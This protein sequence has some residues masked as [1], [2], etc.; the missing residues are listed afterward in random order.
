MIF[1]SPLDGDAVVNPIKSLP[2]NCFLIT[3]LGV[4]R[5]KSVDDIRKAISRCCKNVNFEVIDANARVTGR[6]FLLKNWHL[7]AATPLCVAVIDDDLPDATKANIFYELGVA[8]ALGKEALIVRGKTAAVPSDFVR[9]EYITF[10][11]NFE[12][13][14]AQYLR[15]LSEQA[16]HYEV[17]AEQLD[18]NPILA[19][20]YLRRAF[21]ITGNDELRRRAKEI[22][23][24]AG[25][26]S[27]AKNSIEQLAAAF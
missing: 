13:N 2:R 26:D 14:F 19:I 11:P 3:R 6:Y 18:R 5:P 9:S 25:V 1:Y 7:I 17:V 23:K 8:Q 27:R 12:R 10:D 16:E 20:D 21:L 22:L 15:G 4:P 24:G